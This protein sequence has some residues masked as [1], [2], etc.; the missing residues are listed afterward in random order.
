MWPSAVTRSP[1]ASS[2]AAQVRGSETALETV[3]ADDVALCRYQIADCKQS[4]GAGLRPELSDLPGELMA[5][6]DRRLEA[7]AGPA[8]PL[9]DVE[10]GTADA[11]VM[12]P[13]QRFAGSAGGHGYLPQ[14]DAWSGGLFNQRAHGGSG[15]G[16]GEYKAG[17][18][19]R[20]GKTGRTGRTGWLG[21]S[22]WARMRYAACRLDDYLAGP[23]ITV[24]Y[25]YLRTHQGLGA[26]S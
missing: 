16:R 23:G 6:D 9:P 13:D 11:R 18:T 21:R 12:N 2:P 22:R 1:T 8:I 20:S 14:N 24:A 15:F 25:G 19:G 17:R 7:V 26:L 5:H 4:C 10:V 3:A